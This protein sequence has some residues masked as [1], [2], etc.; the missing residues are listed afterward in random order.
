M[1]DYKKRSLQKEILDQ[2]DIAFADIA[3]NMKELEFINSKLGGHS[4]TIKGFKELLKE[5]KEV[6]V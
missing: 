4:I 3:L 5:K 2:N 1:I 6:S